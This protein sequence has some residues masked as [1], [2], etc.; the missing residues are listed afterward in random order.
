MH[1][2]INERLYSRNNIIWQEYKCNKYIIKYDHLY[3]PKNSPTCSKYNKIVLVS[4]RC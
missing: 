3:E 2:D 1:C 4:I